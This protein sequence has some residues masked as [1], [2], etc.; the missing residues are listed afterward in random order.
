M[1]CCDCKNDKT[2]T[3]TW[4]KTATP[5]SPDK[6]SNIGT[7]Q[8]WSNIPNVNNS[9]TSVNSPW[10]KYYTYTRTPIGGT[11]QQNE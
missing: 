4:D 3:V 11:S 1:P 7:N 10:N 6:P 2:V 9:S 8:T 5:I